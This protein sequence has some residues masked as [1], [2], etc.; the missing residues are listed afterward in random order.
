M[1]KEK[2]P[3]LL[4]TTQNRYFRDKYG[5]SVQLIAPISMIIHGYLHSY[6]TY[7]PTRPG[8]ISTAG[9]TSVGGGQVSYYAIKKIF[10]YIVEPLKN[11]KMGSR[12]E[13]RMS[14]HLA[15]VDEVI[16]LVDLIQQVQQQCETPD[17]INQIT[18]VPDFLSAGEQWVTKPDLQKFRFRVLLR[19]FNSQQ[20][21][22]FL[23]M[24]RNY[25]S[26]IKMSHQLSMKNPYSNYVHNG[27]FY[28]VDDNVL[29]FINL[30]EPGLIRKIYTLNHTNSK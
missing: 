29:T 28:C 26:D 25:G 30:I 9:G 14:L 2:Y 20:K 16:S 5:Y 21:H 1:L 18:A 4:V 6:A 10:D 3:D 13:H 19:P 22:N 15:T 12:Y 24:I 17:L 8:G 23:E 7:D 27:E 11:K